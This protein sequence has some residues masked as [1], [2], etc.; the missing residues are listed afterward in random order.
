MTKLVPNKDQCVL[1]LT[2]PEQGMKKLKEKYEAKDPELM[3]LLAEFK[4]VEIDF[5]RV[6]DEVVN[7]HPDMLCGTCVDKLV[8]KNGTY[9]HA[10]AMFER[11]GAWPVEEWTGY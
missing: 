7:E 1:T 6:V 9:T 8:W 2:M 10:H 5:G 11:H 4:I 3:K